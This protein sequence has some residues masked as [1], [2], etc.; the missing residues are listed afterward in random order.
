[1]LLEPQCTGTIISSQHALCLKIVFWS[2]LTK[3][4]TKPDYALLSHGRDKNLALQYSIWVMTFS[5]HR[6][7]LLLRCLAFGQLL[8][9]ESLLS[10]TGCHKKVGNVI[11]G[12]CRETTCSDHFCL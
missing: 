12:Q 8:K 2:S 11:W 3:S 1:M 10:H 9:L 6:F 4:K 7:L 5:S